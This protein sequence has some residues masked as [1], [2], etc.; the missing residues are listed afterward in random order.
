MHQ[1]GKELSRFVEIWEPSLKEGGGGGGSGRVFVGHSLIIIKWT[2]CF[3]FQN[4][5]SEP[6]YQLGKKEQ[7]NKRHR[8]QSFLLCTNHYLLGVNR[9]PV[10]EC[11]SDCKV[12][13]SKDKITSKVSLKLPS[14]I[15]LR[16]RGARAPR[17]G[18]WTQ[19]TSPS[20]Y[21]PPHPPCPLVHTHKVW[22][23]LKKNIQLLF[24]HLFSLSEKLHYRLLAGL[25]W[26]KETCYG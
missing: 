3:F 21:H 15:K 18:P 14:T 5:Q 12:E 7:W 13:M 20:P 22:K 19:P 10:H 9:L 2:W 4:L 11:K 23:G 1:G 25:M 26:S 24:N 8:K 16:R 17:F 6:S